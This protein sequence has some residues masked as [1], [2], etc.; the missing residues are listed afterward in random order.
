VNSQVIKPVTVSLGG[1]AYNTGEI[2]DYIKNTIPG[3]VFV[4]GYS[5]AE[6]AGSVKA[7]NVVLIGAASAT[8]LTPVARDLMEK[9]IYE[10]VPKKFLDLNM[11][12]FKIGYES[13]K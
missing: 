7:V 5:L 12:A 9:A 3:T 11:E 6:K 1:A 8:G 4:D 10:N 2:I 13:I